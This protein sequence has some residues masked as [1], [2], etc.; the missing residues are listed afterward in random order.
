MTGNRTYL[1]T[2]VAC[3]GVGFVAFLTAACGGGSPPAALQM[4][5]VVLQDAAIHKTLVYESQSLGLIQGMFQL[6]GSDQIAVFGYAG[7]C[8]LTLSGSTATCENMPPGVAPPVSI[9]TFVAKQYIEADFDGDGTVERVRPI[10][11]VGFTLEKI[12]GGELART[13]LERFWVGSDF[14]YWFE[15]AVTWSRPR[16]LLVSTDGTLMLFDSHMKE[17][18]QLPAPGM[19]SPLH[20]SAGAPLDVVGAG[21]F[22]SLFAGRGGWHRSILFIHSADNK[23]VYEEILGDDFQA[24]WPLQAKDGTYRF[25]LGGRSQVWE[26]SFRLPGA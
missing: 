22:A 16:M 6:S 13:Q 19:Q 5:K 10:E 2:R 11:K 14:H 23:V 17:V 4:A 12:Q 3:L 8:L 26:Y 7:N 25:L 18:R 21:P 24:V 20:I 1:V 9:G 15:P